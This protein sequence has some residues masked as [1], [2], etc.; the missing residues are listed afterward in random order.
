[1]TTRPD[2]PGPMH[3]RGPRPLLLHLMLAT[4]NLS[5]WPGGWPT[6]SGSSPS[7]NL[8]DTHPNQ[9][10]SA[11]PPDPSLL[12]G[13]AAYR[14]HSYQRRLRNPPV[15]WEEGGSQ[16]FDFASHPAAAPKVLFVPSL[17]N[18]AYVLDLA[19]GRSA[20]RLLASCGAHPLLLDWGWPGREE[21][22]FNLAGYTARL[23]R[24]LEA[25]STGKAATSEASPGKDGP[26]VLAG[27]CM[28]GLLSVAAA[29][30][31]PDLVSA[32]ALLA[33]PW[34]FQAG[35]EPALVE[36]LPQIEPLLAATM[37]NGTL[38]IDA[39]Q[40][41]FNLIEPG[42]VAA[43]YRAFGRLDQSSARACMFVALEDWLN[44]GVP[45]AAPV[46]GEC[47]GGW[48]RGNSPMRGTWEVEGEAVDPTR[49]RLPSLVA[50][51]GRDRIVPPGSAMPLAALIPGARLLRPAAGHVGMVAGSASD[52]LLWQPMLDWLRTL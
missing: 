3:R 17:I 49:L 35:L 48:Y 2:A 27:Y 42:G 34:D 51:P 11:W 22:C 8:P 18:R 23:E 44:D 25:I 33:T 29:Q 47:F 10:R 43:K 39:M 21:R 30:R 52:A 20:M 32:L 41:L 31:R 36:A 50:I 15:I 45:L 9:A 28:G 5:G 24:A 40:T 37:G 14:R 1:M 7:A 4:A 13:I 38:P 19:E 26:L 46:A 6:S 16:V 12:A